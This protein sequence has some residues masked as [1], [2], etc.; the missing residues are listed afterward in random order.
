MHTPPRQKA[1]FEL[2]GKEVS[3][4]NAESLTGED[5]ARFSGKSVLEKVT[6]FLNLG[7]VLTWA[8][9]SGRT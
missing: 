7:F 9:L 3:G 4:K 5:P 8:W 1:I 6:R 2:N